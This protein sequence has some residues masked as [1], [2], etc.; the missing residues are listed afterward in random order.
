MLTDVR[1]EDPR[2]PFADQAAAGKEGW[3][4]CKG[5]TWPRP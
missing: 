3:D 1:R 5:K 2:W 4:I